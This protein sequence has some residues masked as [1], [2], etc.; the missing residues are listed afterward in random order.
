MAK[1]DKAQFIM[2][3][4]PLSLPEQTNLAQGLGMELWMELEME[5]FTTISFHMFKLQP[6]L[7][8][9]VCEVVFFGN[10]VVF[11]MLACIC[12]ENVKEHALT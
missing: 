8:P 1:G 5:F 6:S 12:N 9:P 2:E 3:A 11:I 7:I 10:L 4:A